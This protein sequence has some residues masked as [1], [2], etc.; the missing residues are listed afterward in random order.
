M[1]RDHD[2][3]LVFAALADE[4]R[5]TVMRCLA[6]GGPS[7]ATQLAAQLPVSRQAVAKHLAALDEA[8]LVQMERCGR[9][10]RYK[11]TP[12]RLTEAVSWMANC[13]AD[14]DDRLAALRRHL[15]PRG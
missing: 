7:T 11:L 9:E 1:A 2:V 12:H 8:G 5:R 13:G 4:T 14:W 15:T 6:D 10:A 3:G